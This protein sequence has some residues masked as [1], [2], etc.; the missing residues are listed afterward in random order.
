[1]DS[2]DPRLELLSKWHAEG[3]LAKAGFAQ[4]NDS[5]FL[6][7][8]E[9]LKHEKA[10]LP[11]GAQHPQHKH[12]QQ[13]ASPEAKKFV[14]IFAKKTH[15]PQEITFINAF[16]MAHPQYA[17]M[18]K[19]KKKH[20]N[21]YVKSP[22]TWS[23]LEAILATENEKYSTE[24]NGALT[25]LKS[26]QSMTEPRLPSGMNRLITQLYTAYMN[27]NLSPE[28]FLRTFNTIIG[29]YLTTHA[30]KAVKRPYTKEPVAGRKYVKESG[31]G[32]I[33][34]FV[35]RYIGTNWNKEQKAAS[36]YPDVEKVL[37]ALNHTRRNISYL[38][39]AIEI[40]KK[41]ASETSNTTNPPTG[42]QKVIKIP[43]G[44]APAAIKLPGGSWETG[45]QFQDPSRATFSMAQPF[46]IT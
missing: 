7:K 41:K 43:G 26:A 4:S 19:G 37:K 3:L 44:S 29:N 39:Q 31:I 13:H 10:T 25:W 40:K 11:G 21:Q 46:P 9:E 45:S 22:Q 15:T 20:P 12:Q 6:G 14:E 18:A 30:G 32:K 38:K 17:K 1:M 2:T 23:E 33:L 28:E 42:T 5:S 16:T 27:S 36:V 34:G 35:N 24:L 8:Y